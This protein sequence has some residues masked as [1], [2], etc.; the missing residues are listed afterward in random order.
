[1]GAEPTTSV[2]HEFNYRTVA[3]IDRHLYTSEIAK[4]DIARTG[5]ASPGSPLPEGI[6][7]VAAAEKA[8]AAFKTI[9]VGD[10]DQW[11]LHS[12]SR[13]QYSGAGWVYYAAFVKRTERMPDYMGNQLQITVLLDGTVIPVHQKPNPGPAE[14]Q[15]AV[16][17]VRGNR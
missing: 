6:G 3:A 11:M 13:K 9:E 7:V 15:D 2:V 1:M 10:H 5:S 14:T 17:G 12:V 8:L 16:Q 4:S